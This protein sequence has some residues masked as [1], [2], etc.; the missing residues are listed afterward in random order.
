M[1]LK[2]RKYRPTEYKKAVYYFVDVGL[3]NFNPQ[4]QYHILNKFKS[5]EDDVDYQ[6]LLQEL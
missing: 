4:S 5:V 3:K 6:S 1:Q 2:K